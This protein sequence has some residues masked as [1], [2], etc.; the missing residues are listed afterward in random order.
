MKS[1]L[2]DDVI[3]R[4]GRNVLT[5]PPTFSTNARYTL[6]S[7][8]HHRNVMKDLKCLDRRTF[9]LQSFAA[10]STWHHNVLYVAAH[11]RRSGESVASFHIS[12]IDVRTGAETAIVDINSVLLSALGDGSLSQVRDFTYLADGGAAVNDEPALCL[13]T[14]GG[15]LFLISLA[16]DESGTLISAPP[17][18]MGSVEQGVLAA[19]W[20]PDEET[21]VLIVPV[22]NGACTST[23][24]QPEKLLVMSRDFEVLDEKII[25]EQ[26]RG[27]DRVSVGW[28]SKATQFHGLAGKIAAQVT[29]DAERDSPSVS[30]VTPLPDDD[31]LPHISWR[32]DCS[33]FSV[34]S[35]EEVETGIRRMIRIFDRSGSLTAVSDDGEVGL[36]HTVAMKP[37]GNIIATSQRFHPNASRA[38]G[39]YAKGRK[40]RHDIVF[41]ERNGLRRGSFSLREEAGARVDGGLGGITEPP[42]PDKDAK[43]QLAN[44]NGWVN[45]HQIVD[46]QWNCDA[47]ALAVWLRRLP[48]KTD[49]APSD[50]VQIWT[51]GNWHWY[52]KQE[53]RTASG[54]MLR[55]FHWH[56]DRSLQILLLSNEASPFATCSVLEVWAFSQLTASQSLSGLYSLSAGVAV[57][58]GSVQRVTFFDQQTVPPPMCSCVLPT[59]QTSV[60][61]SDLAD[62]DSWPLDEGEANGGFTPSDKSWAEIALKSKDTKERMVSFLALLHPAGQVIYLYA[63]SFFSPKTAPSVSYLG[64]LHGPADVDAR[65]IVLH[66]WSDPEDGSAC[67]GVAALGRAVNGTRRLWWQASRI[68]VNVFDREQRMALAPYASSHRDLTQLASSTASILVVN[69]GHIGPAAVC[70]HHSTG[71]IESAFPSPA[72]T[73]EHAAPLADLCE[74]CPSLQ[75]GKAFED[76]NSGYVIGLTSAGSLICSSLSGECESFARKTLARDVTSFAVSP[77][78]LIWTNTIHEARFLSLKSLVSPI[79]SM[80]PDVVSLD[81]RVERGSKIVTTIPRQMAIVLQMPRGNLERIFPRCMVLHRVRKELDARRYLTAFLHCRAHRVDLNVLYDHKPESFLSDVG[82]FVQ[83]VN[84][85]DHLNLFLSSLRNEDVTQTLYQPLEDQKSGSAVSELGSKVNKLC[86]AFITELAALNDNRR[87]VNSILTA[88]VKKTPADYEPALLMLKDLKDSDPQLVDSAIEYI[89]FLA[90]F[91]SLFNVALGMYDL[92]LALMI[93]QHS[94]KKDPR[95][96]LPFLRELRAVEPEQRCRFRI[97][98][99]LGRH[100][101]ALGWLAQ[102]PSDG[103]EETFEMALE[104]MRRYRLFAEAL[105]AWAAEPRKWRRAQGI[106]GEYLLG[107]QKWTDAAVAF[108]LAGDISQALTAFQSAGAWQEAFALALVENRPTTEIISLANTMASRLESTARHSEAARVK[109]EYGQDI[110]GALDSYGKANDITECRRICAAYKRLDLLETHVKPAALQAQSMIVEDVALMKDQLGKQMSRLKELQVKKEEQPAIFYGEDHARLDNIDLLSDASTQIT[111]FT[112]YTK[113]PSHVG[114]LSSISVSSHGT[115]GTNKKV[116]MKM[117]KKEEKKKASGKKGSVYEEDYLYESMQQLI[118][119]RLGEVQEEA[120][121]ILPNLAVFGP[122]HRKAAWMLHRSLDDFE[123]AAEQAIKELSVVSQQAGVAADEAR[124]AALTSSNANLAAPTI[125]LLELLAGSTWLDKAAQRPKMEMAQKKWRSEMLETTMGRRD[126]TT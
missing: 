25:R 40:H 125:G 112:R 122:T 14:A 83:Q 28:G 47:S 113:A 52:L 17:Q 10:A 2:S 22:E 92:T 74:F 61:R 69:R 67:I 104:Y 75:V 63:F 19:R 24:P 101:K 58:D 65:S 124:I 7:K 9:T 3:A 68:P 72:E 71:V 13:V 97:D 115:G 66:A 95:E 86:A 118:R 60:W 98:D 119:E 80:V 89:I 103:N 108:Q 96:Y 79:A 59:T 54:S 30:P 120:S 93:A 100:G 41:L 42:L 4:A 91:D 48:S 5:V 81:R 46:I 64:T 31:G 82:E 33:F 88:H 106:Y 62:L 36:S 1:H 8:L 117:R 37:T 49:I 107:R 76:S 51:M 53:L 6:F 114:T 126:V 45:S 11:S 15:D 38:A 123:K 56:P 20:S 23:E 21:L 84:N 87:W 121:K 105:Q 73:E 70:I 77:P 90:P 18:I 55:T 111:Q 57:T 26:D 29:D 43:K 12:S 32:S 27:E 35:L 44:D 110:E 34:S 116:E 109:L 78:F 39:T 102:L 85:V 94:K 16:Q 99:H 50:V